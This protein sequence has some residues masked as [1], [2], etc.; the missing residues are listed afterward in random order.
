VLSGGL[1]AGNVAG[2]IA[3]AHPFAVDVAS[4]VEA[5][6]GIKDPAALRDFLAAAGAGREAHAA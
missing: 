1:N 2:A 4:G 3:S 5:A 6:P